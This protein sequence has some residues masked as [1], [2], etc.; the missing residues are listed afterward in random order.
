[1]TPTIKER[2]DV[3]GCGCLD[4]RNVQTA[5]TERTVLD[6]LVWSVGLFRSRPSIVAFAGVIVLANRLLETDVITVLPLPVVDL[7]EAAAAFAFLF[8][9]RAYVG[10]I[11]AG[12]LTGDPVTIRE[13]IQRSLARTPALVG[14]ILLIVGFVLT[15]PSLVGLP[16]LVLVGVLPGDPVALVGFPVAAAVGGAVFLVPMLLLLFTFWFAPEACVIGR[17][18]PVESLRVSWHVT[19][20]YRGKFVLIVVLVLGSVLGLQ[21]PASLP[22]TGARLAWVAPAVDVIAASVSEL[23][24]IVWASAYAHVY[25]QAIVS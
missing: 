10:T 6:A 9:I 19:T 11:V 20:N 17:Y 5:A 15:I 7:F 16:L 24:S 14:V 21:L 12:E 4:C 25:V 8:L 1:M 22:E 2:T 13:G 18:G 23:L 3:D